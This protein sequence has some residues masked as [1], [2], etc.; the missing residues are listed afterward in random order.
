MGILHEIFRCSNVQV[1]LSNNNSDHPCSTI[2]QYQQSATQAEHQMPEPYMGDL[3][4]APILF[5]GSNPSIGYDHEYPSAVANDD[6]IYDFFTNH[7]GGGRKE[8][9]QEGKFVIGLDGKRKVVSYWAE[10]KKRAME[11]LERDD[12]RPGVDY[13][14]SEVVH[15]KS[16]SQVGVSKALDECSTRYLLRLVEESGAKVVVTLGRFTERAVRRFFEIPLDAKVYGSTN[17]GSSPTLFTFLPH[18]SSWTTNLGVSLAGNLSQQEL[19]RLQN[20]L[21]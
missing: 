12:V 16:K 19:E 1:C 3:C 6:E 14:L 8:W 21:R 13:A 2:V 18:P 11:L 20:A 17:V 5:L 9:V 15:C 10:V 7:F 4:G